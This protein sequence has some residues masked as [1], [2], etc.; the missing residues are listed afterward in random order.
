MITWTNNSTDNLNL[1]N[2]N[3]TASWTVTDDG[4]VTTG[5]IPD[6]IRTGDHD[7][8][9]Q[10]YFA[11]AREREMMVAQGVDTPGDVYRGQN[12]QVSH[13]TATNML[14]ISEPLNLELNNWTVQVTQTDGTG[15]FR[16][17]GWGGMTDTWVDPGCH[18]WDLNEGDLTH[19]I[20]RTFELDGADGLQA[21]LE[22]EQPRGGTWRVSYQLDDMV[23]TRDVTLPRDPDYVYVPFDIDWTL[24]VNNPCNAAPW[25]VSRSNTRLHYRVTNSKNCGGPCDSIQAGTATANIRVGTTPVNMSFVFEGIGER[26]MPNYELMDFRLDGAIVA[27]GHAP[28][29]WLGCDMG[30]IVQENLGSG[31]PYLLQANTDYVFSCNFTTN[32]NLYHVGCYYQVDLVFED[33]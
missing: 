3:D 32:D 11:N 5:V 24:T 1:W 16:W 13:D 27:R 9:P 31:P 12:G 23:L 10:F 30:P 21:V 2:L 22:M 33:A 6:W 8:Q 7:D 26:M 4:D 19:Q 25:T 15:V 17:P 28:G 20:I 29:G 18:A 14:T